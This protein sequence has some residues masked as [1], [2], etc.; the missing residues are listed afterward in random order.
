MSKGNLG[1]GFLPLDD[2]YSRTHGSCLCQVSLLPPLWCHLS[3]RDPFFFDLRAKVPHKVLAFS[4]IR[5]PLFTPGDRPGVNKLANRPEET[6]C[7]TG[8]DKDVYR[9]VVLTQLFPVAAEPFRGGNDKGEV[10]P[11]STDVHGN[12][13]TSTAENQGTLKVLAG[14][15]TFLKHFIFH[16]WFFL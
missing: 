6:A 14:T 11:R 12:L 2:S 1:L 9:T 4:P 3:G 10:S 8:Q 13:K 7:H 15:Q 5:S 16:H